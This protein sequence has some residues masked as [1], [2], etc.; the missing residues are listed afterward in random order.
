LTIIATQFTMAPSGGGAIMKKA[1]LVLLVVASAVALLAWQQASGQQKESQVER[2]KYL[3][4]VAGCNDCHTPL[5][6]GP[7]GPEP[8]MSRMLSGHPAGFKVPPPVAPVPAGPWMAA[9]TTTMTAW[10][11]PWGVS[12][13]ANLTPDEETGTGA[14]DV[15]M[16][17]KALRTGRHLGAGR[18]I[19]PP[20]PWQSYS[21]MTDRDLEAIFAYLRTIP[22]IKN[23]VPDPIINE[24]P[25]AH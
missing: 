16:F 23:Q 19:L 13:T 17:I 20:M 14:W 25:A 12:Y 4:T 18:P 21:Q 9:V 10:A 5:K 15:N 22:P 11:G 3:V 1:S 8:D 2:G 24:A 6:M 7:K